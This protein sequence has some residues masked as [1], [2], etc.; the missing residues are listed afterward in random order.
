MNQFTHKP[1]IALIAD[2][3]GWVFTKLSNSISKYLSDDFSF[4]IFHIADYKH[5]AEV[6]FELNNFDLVHFFFREHLKVALDLFQVDYFKNSKDYEDFLVKRVGNLTVSTSVF[7]HLF[8]SEDDIKK[9]EGCFTFLLSGY[10]VSS[11]KLDKIYR[12]ISNYPSPDMVI[13]D[14][15]DL[16]LFKPCN[17]G[18]L[19]DKDRDIVIGWSGNSRW[20]MH[21]DG[22]DHK[23]LLTIIKVAVEELQKEGFHLRGEFIDRDI[24]PRP[25]NQMPD[26][27]NSVDIYV[28]A[29][30]TEGTP[31]PVLEAMA[32]G[33]PV[34]STDVGIVPDVFGIEQ[35]RF[36][37][38]RNVSSLKEKLRLLIL[39][40]D[41]RGSLSEENLKS[42]QSWSVQR[43]MENWKL[44]FHTILSAQNAKKGSEYDSISSNRF[45]NLKL[46]YLWEVA[47]KN[48][49]IR[50]RSY[51]LGESQRF[52]SQL[53][54]IQTSRSYRAIEYFRK[55]KLGNVFCSIARWMLH[56]LGLVYKKVK[57][58]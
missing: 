39:K 38:D 25:H 35:S 42:I 19:V 47:Q 12:N 4:T 20:G 22:V 7:D 34:I 8:L 56:L 18:R 33:I 55:T 31:N 28:C 2:T 9:Y 32:C 37:I 36:I 5:P 46:L 10:S 40:P 3:P 44:F 24:N 23:G 51:F 14:G 52:S 21:L 15:V 43:K 11:N 27:F 16:D 45:K 30:D 50:E 57:N 6:F 26:Y 1:S 29:S 17:L 53:W 54:A 58:F 41:L 48:I 13:E 49:A